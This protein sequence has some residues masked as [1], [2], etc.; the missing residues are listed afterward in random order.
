MKDNIVPLPK[1]RT[2]YPIITIIIKKFVI[3]EI[4]NEL[5][6]FKFLKKM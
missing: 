4:E 3:Y 2:T 5:K 1:N 6:Q